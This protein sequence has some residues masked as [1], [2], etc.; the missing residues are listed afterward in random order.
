MNGVDDPHRTPLPYLRNAPTDAPEI[1]VGAIVSV[2]SSVAGILFTI[3]LCAGVWT[4]VAP[5]V[6]NHAG[7]ITGILAAISVVS[8]GIGAIQAPKDSVYYRISMA[9]Y[10]AGMT[11]LCAAAVMFVSF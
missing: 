1:N 5:F 2:A 6:A 11:L 8:S 3:S 4:H 9:G 10:I 7:W